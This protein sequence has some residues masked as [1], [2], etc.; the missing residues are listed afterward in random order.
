MRTNLTERLRHALEHP[1][2]AAEFAKRGQAALDEHRGATA[3]TAGGSCSAGWGD[4]AWPSWPCSGRTVLMPSWLFSRRCDWER[5]VHAWSAAG[6]QGLSDT[7]RSSHP[8]QSIMGRM[9]MPTRLQ[10]GRVGG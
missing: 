1:D 5:R 2:E 7:P 3:R 9:P 4:V 10:S 6:A 8:G